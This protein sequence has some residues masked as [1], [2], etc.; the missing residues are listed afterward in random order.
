LVAFNKKL[1]KNI[2]FEKILKFSLKNNFSQ[3]EWLWL[4]FGLR[5]LT[6]NFFEGRKIK[7]F[8]LANFK[9][10][11]QFYE[12]DSWMD[13]LQRKSPL[14]MQA[15]KLRSLKIAFEL[16]TNKQYQEAEFLLLKK[17]QQ[18][19]FKGG[20]LADS[21]NDFTIRP[22]VFLA[23]YFYPDLLKKK[24]WQGCFEIALKKLWLDWGGLSTLD[25]NHPSFCSFS[26][27]EDP[28]SYHQGD[29]WFFVNNLAALALFRVNSD[30]FSFYIKKIL[31][32]SSFEILWQGVPG[33]H[34]ELSSAFKLMPTGCFC[35]AWSCS[36][37]LEALRE[38]RFR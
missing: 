13:T 4:V 24:Q 15:L 17:V 1:R 11:N 9:P 30:K 8:L 3:E 27:G 6:F 34:S 10:D 28:K 22:N 29:S 32:A 36:S 20:L 26:T 18:K 35:Q 16:T 5:E 21:E 14:E 12:G 2:F 33:S 38:I 7:N 31:K 23:H 25:R 37:L 19:F